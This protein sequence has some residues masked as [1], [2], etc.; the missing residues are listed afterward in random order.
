MGMTGGGS[1]RLEAMARALGRAADGEIAVRAGDRM[2]KRAV[3]LAEEGFSKGQDPYGNAWEPVKRG[4]GHP[5][6]KSGN[7]YNSA[8]GVSNGGKSIEVKFS[9]KYAYPLHYGWGTAAHAARLQA[10]F[11]K[12]QVSMALGEKGAKRKLGRATRRA[13]AF[14]SLSSRSPGRALLPKEAGKGVGTWERPLREETE[15]AAKEVMREVL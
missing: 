7:L 4:S 10:S 2:A 3:Q 1:R 6:F 8:T 5:L 13:N 9:A 11:E 12:A 14:L 15:A